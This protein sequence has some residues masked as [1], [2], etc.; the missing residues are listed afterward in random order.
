M[1]FF[2]ASKNVIND[3]TSALSKDMSSS[4]LGSDIAGVA[5]DIAG[6][7]SAVSKGA[8]AVSS[9]INKVKGLFRFAE[10]N[11]GEMRNYFPLFMSKYDQMKKKSSLINNDTLTNSTENKPSIQEMPRFIEDNETISNETNIKVDSNKLQMNLGQELDKYVN[12]SNNQNIE[13]S[14]KNDLETPNLKNQENFR[15][16]SEISTARN[17]NE[18]HPNIEINSELENKNLN[19]GFQEN[20]NNQKQMENNNFDSNKNLNNLPNENILKE[21]TPEPQ[22]QNSL[23]ASN[24]NSNENAINSNEKAQSQIEKPSEISQDNINI[25]TPDVCEDLMKKYPYI[26]FGCNKNAPT[27]F[28]QTKAKLK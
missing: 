2:V 16:K 23:E 20:I 19:N 4:S 26:D 15:G 14:S 27:S 5:N 18:L 17:E 24:P 3:I 12:D 21:I 1:P 9:G 8:K 28:L 7:A 10:K 25:L 22:N 6:V 11:E 13:K